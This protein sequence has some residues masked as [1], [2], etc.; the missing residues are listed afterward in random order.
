MELVAEFDGKAAANEVHLPGFIHWLLER[1]KLEQ[2][3]L[4]SEP[5]AE[6]ISSKEEKSGMT[7]DNILTILLT[8][9][10]RYAKH[11]TKKALEGSPLSTLDDFTFLLT[12]KYQGSMTKSELTNQHML[13]ITSGIEILKRLS[14][15]GFIA[16]FSDPND[17]R[18]KQVA[19]TEQ[20]LEVVDHAMVN[21]EKVSK[22]VAGNLGPAELAQLLPLLTHLH[23]F[24]AEIY[25][26]DKK[27]ELG[28]IFDKY[29][30]REA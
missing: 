19:I 9:L 1:N 29:L 16:T 12:L 27:S 22:I 8:F 14:K 25:K 20:G 23:G 5:S 30:V 24:H 4:F 3:L 11:Y 28:E 15:Q 10:F 2:D 6:I 21:M 13:E 7:P 18:S 26:E 17:G